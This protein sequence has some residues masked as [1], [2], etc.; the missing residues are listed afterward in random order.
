MLDAR[1]LEAPHLG[2][3]LDPIAHG[4][5]NAVYGYPLRDLFGAPPFLSGANVM[6]YSTA[7]GSGGGGTST[8]LLGWTSMEAFASGAAG[9]VFAVVHI[10][11]S[12]QRGIFAGIGDSNGADTGLT[13]GVGN[14]APDA[15]GNNLVGIRGGVN[16]TTAGAAIGQGLRTVALSLDGSSASAWYV[17]GVRVSTGGTGGTW[18]CTSGVPALV[19]GNHQAGS[20]SFGLAA[21]AAVLFAAA[22]MRELAPREVAAMHDDPLRIVAQLDAR[23]VWDL[24]PAGA[25]AG[26]AQRLKVRSGGVWVPGTLKV[27]SGGAWVEGTPYHRSGGAWQ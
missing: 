16:Y 10:G 26:P 13:L 8:S 19:V 1:Y 6:P 24:A 21:G 15:V 12:S 25:A 22:W 17:D 9:T 14:T 11:S 2:P 27:R 5:I 7:G 20:A 18:Q 23:S 3:S 4:L